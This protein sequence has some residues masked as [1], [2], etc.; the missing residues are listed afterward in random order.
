MGWV[1]LGWVEIFRVMDWLGWEHY[2]KGTKKL[3]GL[4]F[5]ARS[6]QKMNKM[7]LG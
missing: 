7:M 5:K 1:W 6:A 3:K 2:S 4:V